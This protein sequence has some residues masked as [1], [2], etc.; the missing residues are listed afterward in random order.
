MMQNP[1]DGL[2]VD[3]KSLLDL[4]KSGSE[5]IAYVQGAGL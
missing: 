4:M 2:L 3:N 1:P 5:G